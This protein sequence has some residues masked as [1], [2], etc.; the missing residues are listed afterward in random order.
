MFTRRIF[1][2]V[3]LGLGMS[4][5]VQAAW[6]DRPI[7]IIVPF[8]PGGATDVSARV[9]ADGL[10]KELRQPVVIENRPGNGGNIGMEHA[11]AAKPD[12][13]TFL[14][15]TQALVTFNPHLQAEM[16]YDPRRDLVPVGNAFQT[17]MILVV[18]K[19]MPP[20][21]EG[22]IATA[23]ANPSKLTYGS[24]GN[25]SA[26]HVLAELM[27]SM[28]GVDIRHIPYKGTAPALTDLVAGTINIL[29]DSVPSALGQIRSGTI[30]AVAI[31]GPKRNPRLPSVPTFSEA[32][33]PEYKASAWLGLMAPRGT[34]DEI[35]SSL[36][37]AMRHTLSQS[38]IADRSF[39]AGMDIDYLPASIFVARIKDD[40]VL[41]GK[42]I[43]DSGIKLN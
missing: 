12:G 37:E 4:Q 31:C 14:M 13:Y 43:R 38:E 5:M 33:L 32:G 28:A 17:D 29:I 39:K 26:A 6:P 23:K 19:S 20:T 40:S 8:A 18:N 22:I 30:Q 41:W 21:L 3:A 42:V 15:V 35:V 25:G 16:K 2:A 36:S 34:P 27:K 10:S 7:T 24:A 9:L 11:A 1:I